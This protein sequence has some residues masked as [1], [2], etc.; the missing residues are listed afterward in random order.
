MGTRI[1][2]LS[3]KGYWAKVFESNRDKKGYN[4]QLVDIGGQTTIDVDL[5][6]RHM[7]LLKK[8]GSMLQGNPSPDNDGLTR[9]KFRRRWTEN[10][11]GG[12]P[13]IERAD[14]TAWD[15]ET[16]GLIGNGSDVEITLNV[17]D[18]R[19]KT[20]VGTRLEKVKVT[21]LVPY[22]GGP[23]VMTV[24]DVDAPAPAP[25]TQP[26]AQADEIPF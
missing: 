5:D 17:Y 3:G 2:K 15:I 13:K 21:N 1:V 19:N 20:I 23:V 9:V 16:D 24:D 18:T 10:Y 6:A 7:A 14:G 11:G 4:D 26:A 8:S 12:E 22:E 25:A